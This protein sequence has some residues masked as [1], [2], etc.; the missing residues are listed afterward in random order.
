MSTPDIAA[1]LKEADELPDTE[2]C[3]LTH[4]ERVLIKFCRRLAD[5]FRTPAPSGAEAGGPLARVDYGDGR[6][7]PAMFEIDDEL[8]AREAKLIA[9]SHGYELCYTAHDAGNWSFTHGDFATALAEVDPPAT[10]AAGNPLVGA[11]D[12][13]DGEIVLAFARPLPTPPA[14]V[15]G[16]ADRG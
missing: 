12:N 16:S 15:E 8:S 13:E 10:D 2:R 14:A 6:F 5:A 4:N 11:W 9:A 3:L 1:L 7:G